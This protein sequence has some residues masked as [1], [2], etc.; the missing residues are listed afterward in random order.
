MTNCNCPPTVEGQEYEIYKT[1]NTVAENAEFFSSACWKNL[2][3]DQKL[4]LVTRSF[5]DV[6]DTIGGR[7]PIGN[8]GPEGPIGDVGPDGPEGQEGP[9]GIRGTLGDEGPEGPEVDFRGVVAN[10]A[11]LPTPS[12]SGYCYFVQDESAYYVYDG[13]DWIGYG[14]LQGQNGP[15]GPDGPPGSTGPEGI[16]GSPGAIGS[17]GIPGPDGIPGVSGGINASNIIMAKVGDNLITKYAQAALLATSIGATA[18]NRVALVILPGNYNITNTLTI[19]ADFVDVIGLGSSPKNPKVNI[20]TASSTGV[21][22]TANDVRIIGL[23]V[24][25]GSWGIEITPSVN[26]FFQNC[27]STS[28]FG[29]G[30][31]SGT[32]VNCVAGPGPSTARGFSSSTSGV[33]VNA[34]GTYINCSCTDGF[35]YSF[36]PGGGERAATASGTFIKCSAVKGFAGSAGAGGGNGYSN[37]SGT[38]IE[39]TATTAFARDYFSGVAKNCVVGANSF[40]SGRDPF[41][42]GGLGQFITGKIIKCRKTS[43]AYGSMGT[44]GQIRFSLDGSNNIVNLG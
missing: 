6:V 34:S 33:N 40:G 41:V 10:E 7:G 4:C 32:F 27:T 17:D 39:C 8:P 14:P 37:A 11:A 35:G 26:Q 28:S 42:P 1:L 23:S 43:V 29:R 3:D 20:L 36:N 12:T 30:N 2:S 13:S 19:G 15:Q 9:E 16:E 44:G 18:T 5:I 22:V 38:F 25:A 24:S 31:T 21:N